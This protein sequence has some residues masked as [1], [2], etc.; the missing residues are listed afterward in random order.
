MKNSL[1]ICLLTAL[2]FFACEENDSDVKREEEQLDALNL[3][4]EEINWNAQLFGEI[5]DEASLELTQDTIEYYLSESTTRAE[6][7]RGFFFPLNGLFEKAIQRNNDYVDVSGVNFGPGVISE[8]RAD[9]WSRIFVEED[10]I[11]AYYDLLVPVI[12]LADEEHRDWVILTSFVDA[13]E[14]THDLPLEHSTLTRRIARVIINMKDMIL[15]APENGAEGAAIEEIFVTNN[16]PQPY[17]G[18]LLPAVQKVRE[19][20]TKEPFNSWID[21]NTEAG[22][23]GGLNRD[24][25]RRLQIVSLLSTIDLILNEEYDRGDQDGFSVGL[26]Q[27]QYE[28]YWAFIA[29]EY[30]IDKL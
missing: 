1:L 29:N 21:A 25:I 18:L 5:L 23:N 14:S 16:V 27:A 9:F 19:V 10:P 17:I 13:S 2:I 30:W 28:A 12:D 7:I 26:M 8:E 24:I 20:E 3:A 22:I 15:D 6:F 4:M 11:Q